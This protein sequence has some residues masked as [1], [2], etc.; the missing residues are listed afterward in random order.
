[1]WKR[2]IK[3]I[4]VVVFFCGTFNFCT[5]ESVDQVT[6]MLKKVIEVSIDGSSTTTTLSYDGLK[7]KSIDKVDTFF[8]FYYTGKLITRIVETNKV[9][10]RKNT[11]DYSY[12]D[13]FLSSI[14][15]SENYVVQFKQQKGGAV[16]YEKWTKNV[17]NVAVKVHRGTLYFENANLVKDET[18]TE[19]SMKGIVT[20]ITL[21]R[22]FDKGKNPMYHILG[23]DKLLDF[24]ATISSNNYIIVIESYTKKDL[25]S[26]QTISSVK[27]VE[28]TI[29][30]NSMQYPTEIVSENLF[31][32]GRDSKHLKSQLF[33][34]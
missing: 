3:Q 30:Y 31:F 28:S 26:G 18:V 25:N 32:V 1:M 29:E 33:Y 23:F 8:E 4:V 15:S 21:D 10:S 34:N 7:I 2:L 9:T 17:N 16:S 11:L 5:N 6:P 22:V 14:S 13:G 24:A 19:D 12:V 20:T 27:R